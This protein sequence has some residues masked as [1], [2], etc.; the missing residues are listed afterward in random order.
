MLLSA[1]II[2]W[3]ANNLATETSWNTRTCIT[4]QTQR[5][6]PKLQCQKEVEVEAIAVQETGKK[7]IQNGTEVLKIVRFWKAP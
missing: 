4:Q 7:Y 1:I 6:N 5:K 2:F 3:I